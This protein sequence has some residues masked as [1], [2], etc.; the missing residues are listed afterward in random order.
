MTIIS[1]LKGRGEEEAAQEAEYGGGIGAYYRG[2]RQRLKIAYGKSF[3]VFLKPKKTK[4]DKVEIDEVELPEE[5][6]LDLEKITEAGRQS[7][8][9]KLY[10]QLLSDVRHDLENARIKQAEID[11]GV[12]LLAWQKAKTMQDYEDLILLMVASEDI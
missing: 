10:D 4:K 7:L 2:R 8:R 9:R 5:I 3:T 11:L 1:V 12:L 6:E